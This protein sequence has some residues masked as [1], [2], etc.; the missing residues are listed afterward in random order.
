MASKA[1]TLENL[2][3]NFKDQFHKEVVDLLPQVALLQRG[4]IDFVP[5]DKMNGE[6]YSVPTLLK[7][8][9]GVSYMGES[10][11]VGSLKDAKPGQMREAQVK[12]SEINVRGQLA[13][14]ALSQ[15][16]SAG[17]RAF[18]K[19][20]AWLVEDLTNVAHTRLEIAAL[21]GREGLGVVQT[22]TDLGSNLADVV[23]TEGSFAPGI[24]VPLEG[25]TIEAFTGNTKNSSTAHEIKKVTTSTRTIQVSYAGTLANE[26]TA[27]DDLFFEGAATADGS[28]RS[29]NE[30]VGL[31]Q[32]FSATSGTM[33]NLDRGAHGLIQGNVFIPGDG[34]NGGP[35]SKYEIIHAAMLAVD[36]GC[37]S[38]LV[39]LVGT[40][41]W[42]TLWAED[43]ALR[44][45]DS[46]TASLSRSRAA[47]RLSTSRSMAES[48]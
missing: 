40:K 13:Y 9:Q 15:A 1:N 30:M 18:K 24:W 32:Q 4:L 26:I 28:S 27:G 48:R 41:A 5:S 23:I 12:G 6:F 31:S 29:F 39:V 8:N 42:A 35:I 37:M 19:A 46:A 21:Y 2:D 34:I 7:S 14:K 22:V 17:P 3:G 16:A 10:G 38:E 45:F 11:V 33:F 44:R 43:V 36:K 47:R 20:S 25:A